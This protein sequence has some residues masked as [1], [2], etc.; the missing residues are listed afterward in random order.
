M[1]VRIIGVIGAGVIGVGVSQ[2]L[3][4]TRHQV[5][6]IDVSEEILDRAEQ[7][8]QKNIR[9]HSLL[10]KSVSE[11]PSDVLDRITFS[12]DYQLLKEADFVIENVTES[13]DV[14]RSVYALIDTICPDYCVFA[15]NTSAIPITRIASVTKRAENVIGIHF[16][17]PVALK[18]MVEVIRGY[19]TS[20]ETLEISKNLLMRMGKEC[21]I[22]NDSPGFVSNRVMMLTINEAISLIQDQLR[23]LKTWI[24][25]S[26]PALDIKWGLWKRRT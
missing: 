10:K 3:A 7:E 22:V 23:R 9:L 12:T 16:M 26:K 21:I 8:I 1:D 13:W 15:A 5:I 20:S 6:F 18:T 11:S 17:N 25:F 14:K 24:D 2:N 19:H 4:Q